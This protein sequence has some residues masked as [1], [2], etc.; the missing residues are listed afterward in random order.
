MLNF[1]QIPDKLELDTVCYECDEI[2]GKLNKYQNI[3]NKVWSYIYLYET[4]ENFKINKFDSKATFSI[5]Q[6]GR[7]LGHIVVNGLGKIIESEYYHKDQNANIYKRIFKNFTSE[8]IN[9]SV[10]AEIEFVQ[11]SIKF[12]PKADKQVLY[13]IA[14]FIYHCGV[15]ADEVI[16]EQ[17]RAGYC[18]HFAMILKEM[19]PGGEIC[20]CAPVGHMIYMY[21]DNPYDIEG[22]SSSDCDYYIPI[23]FI[24]EGI[25]DFMHIP[26]IGFNASEEYIKDAIERYKAYSLHTENYKN[27]KYNQIIKDNNNG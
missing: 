27:V 10:L 23:S 24:K 15:D 16:Y 25:K 20:W 4:S 12:C 5:R 6:P 18:L 19:F 22:V 17:F 26:G 2:T 8:I 13:F 3:E 7:T 14:N 1:R 21:K 11:S 9:L